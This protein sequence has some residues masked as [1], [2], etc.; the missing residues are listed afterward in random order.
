[1]IMSAETTEQK[2]D[3]I[4]SRNER[5]DQLMAKDDKERKKTR[6][7]TNAGVIVMVIIFI[8]MFTLMIGYYMGYNEAMN[9]IAREIAF[10]SIGLNI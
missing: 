9:K 1:M 5:I 8:A 4:T 2:I 7:V 3:A 10:Q 6:D